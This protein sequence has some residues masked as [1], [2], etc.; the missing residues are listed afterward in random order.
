[1]SYRAGAWALALCYLMTPSVESRAQ[2]S[3]AKDYSY[4]VKEASSTRKGS[5][6]RRSTALAEQERITAISILTSLADE[7]ERYKD[8][9]LRVRTQ[10]RV[11]D[12]LWDADETL[13]RGLFLRAWNT[14][15]E[16]DT[17]SDK[18]IAEARKKALSNRG[19][20]ITILPPVPNLRSE[21]LKLAARRDPALGG[22]LIARLDEST[23]QETSA[24]DEENTSQSFF[25]PTEPK[26]AIAKRL[27]VALQLLDAGDL[28]QAKE[29]ASPA[30]NY[31]TSQG[32]IFLCAL[33]QKDVHSADELYAS[34][35]THADS[36][37]RTDATTVSLLSSYLFTP[38]L[39][40]TATQRGRVSNQFG[41]K[42]STRDF[43][44]ALRANFF[45]V[46]ARILLRR[47]SLSDLDRTSAG[48]AGTYFT[49]ARLLPLFE[50][51][52]GDYVPALNAQLALLAPDA[53][54]TFR[55]GEEGM[56]KA[57]LVSST[58]DLDALPDILNQLSNVT[59]STDRD[60][61]FVKAIRAG[62][63]SGDRR[64]LQFA[65][66]VD[67]LS[68]KERARSF[69]AL[70]AVRSSINQKDTDGALRIISDGYL[71][72]LHRAWA[73]AQVAR[74]LKQS[75]PDRALQAINDAAVEANRI[76]LGE[77]D[78]VYA[79][80][81]VA[82]LLFELD[83]GRWWNVVS[84]VIKAANA[85]P[86]FSGEE[87]KLYAL[88]RTRDVIATINSDEPSFNI[89]RVFDLLARDDL[90]LA[91]SVAN[92]LVGEAPRSGAN[93]AIARSVLNRQKRPPSTVRK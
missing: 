17:A 21:V 91:V 76:G 9:T 62:A 89:M 38:N 70:A 77:P 54:E 44:P 79:L 31:A 51:Y 64:I 25:D 65:E 72:P 15:E 32:I 11:A 3:A 57:G 33:Q 39:L 7:S 49:I 85:V 74:L 24:A 90:E 37:S 16:V 1:M 13:A 84:D 87:G 69:S 83:H 52:A 61:M 78:R 88:L 71:S 22:I 2:T 36:D 41:D 8:Q 18:H 81:C 10:A 26:L 48:R 93:L 60:A 73:L 47:V 42:V 56:L 82:L 66:K 50:Q 86:G 80:V 67:N 4:A 20:G 75:D 19:G 28:K 14:A 23:D 92:N 34:L 30:L 68:L 27:E 63:I 5:K 55:N 35:L 12:A 53:P 45:G 46:A 6:S 40:V 58:A 43:S 29:F 59:S